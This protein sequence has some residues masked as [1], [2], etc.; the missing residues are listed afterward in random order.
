[1][2]ALNLVR[3]GLSSVSELVI[4][5]ENTQSREKHISPARRAANWKLDLSSLTGPPSRFVV[6][7][8]LLAGASHFAGMKIVLARKFPN[9]PVSG[10]F[11][12]RRLPQRIQDPSA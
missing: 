3:P 8:D 12:A 4:Q 2:E 6:F 11:L 10:L 9:V 7:D 1:L 5:L